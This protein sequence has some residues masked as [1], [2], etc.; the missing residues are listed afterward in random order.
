MRF[1]IIGGSDAGIAAGLRAHELD[2]SCEI[3]LALADAS[4]NYS[5]TGWTSGRTNREGDRANQS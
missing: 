3:T 2:P 1:L 4:P 5:I